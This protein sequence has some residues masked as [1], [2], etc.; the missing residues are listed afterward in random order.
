MPFIPL[1]I[2]IQDIFYTYKKNLQDKNDRE[3]VTSRR[4]RHEVVSPAGAAKKSLAT[5]APPTLE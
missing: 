5:K 4:R 1:I 3:G 2:I